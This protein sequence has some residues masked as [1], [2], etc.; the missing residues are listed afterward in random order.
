M[1]AAKKILMVLTSHDQLGNTEHKT[2]F[3]VEEFAAPYYVFLDA[4]SEITLASPNGG[5]PPIDPSSEL[6][7][8]QT[9]AT[10]R[11]DNDDA[12]KQQL[13]TTLKLADLDASDYDAVF[14]P[15]GHGPLWDLTDNPQSIAL[16]E[17]FIQQNKPV[18]AVCHATAA[19]L[20][21]KQAD[22]QLLVKG[23][24]VTGFTNSEEAA[25]QLTEVVPFLLEDEL[26][27]RGA[28]YQ[29]VADWSPFAVQDGLMITGQNPAS[30]EM[31]AEK[32]LQQFA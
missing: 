15:G 27:A 2:G 31:A 8:F 23:K 18:S 26:K 29:S 22:G 20:N 4:G 9:D 6:A 24:A 1:S 10:R 32:L 12:A 25:V 19:L 17:S 11:F 7:D 14:Y 30:S 21:V 16:L 13:A 5:Q 28:D 3:W